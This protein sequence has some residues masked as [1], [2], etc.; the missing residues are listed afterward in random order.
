MNIYKYCYSIVLGIITGTCIDY[1]LNLS[2]ENA[3]ILAFILALIMFIVT[4]IDEKRNNIL[5]KNIN[6]KKEE[7]HL[8]YKNNF[9]I[10]ENF[11]EKLLNLIS[12]NND[13]IVNSI[14]E[15]EK[16]LNESETKS[17]NQYEKMNNRLIEAIINFNQYVD[18]NVNEL[19]E[20]YLKESNSINDLTKKIIIS[21]EEIKEK[22]QDIKSCNEKTLIM[23]TEQYIN[24]MKSLQE[25][26][27]KTVNSINELISNNEKFA[28]NIQ[29]KIDYI[30]N[31]S[32]ECLQIYF[33]D[34]IEKIRENMKKYFDENICQL[35][36]KVGS[37]S[38]EI[39]SKIDNEFDKIDEFN[40][41]FNFKSEDLN[42][43]IGKI[44]ET[45]VKKSES[46]L[47]NEN[48]ILEEYKILQNEYIKNMLEFSERSEDILKLL[49]D[50]Y[51]YLNSII[52]KE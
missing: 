21:N 7:E 29:K 23:Q 11:Q 22:L 25:V 26:N 18:N 45:I 8:L 14:K 30:S 47:N 36:D 48:K 35:L 41:D 31:D 2:N 19:K 44:K 37:I 6:E 9:S 28:L 10:M 5:Q 52:N 43:N 51:K 34:I 50:S 17:L 39:N 46:L 42:N 49:N 32:K 1:I 13:K 16:K 40:Q 24:E 27:I 38:E 3:F 12:C 33:N 15:I 4:F 20:I